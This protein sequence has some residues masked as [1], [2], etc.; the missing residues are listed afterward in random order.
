MDL[1]VKKSITVDKPVED[2]WKSCWE[3]FGDIHK[4]ASA[5]KECTLLKDEG[6]ADATITVDGICGRKLLMS[7]GATF[8]EWLIKVDKKEH[9]ISYNAMGFPLGI[10]VV[11]TWGVSKSAEDESKAELELEFHLGLKYLPPTFLLYPPLSFALAGMNKT[12]LADV[13]HYIETG[14]PSSAK[15][16]ALKK[17]AG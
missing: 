11:S 10:P 4:S 1:V 7:D 12:M 17:A 6:A 15:E 9:V 5:V 3:G 16:E 14:S 8:H 2:V 13:K